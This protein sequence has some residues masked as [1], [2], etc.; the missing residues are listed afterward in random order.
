M[1]GPYVFAVDAALLLSLRETYAPSPHGGN[2]FRSLLHPVVC[3][4]ARCV[5]LC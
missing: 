1:T 4:C 2:L 3:H 5:K